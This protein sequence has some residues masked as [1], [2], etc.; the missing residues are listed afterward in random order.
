M[1]KI[2]PLTLLKIE[3]DGWVC[4]ETRKGTCGL[5]QAGM[6]AND[7]SK[8]RLQLAGYYQTSTTPG[9]W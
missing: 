3:H 8:E 7:L 5:P 2:L 1:T 6:L 4:V 9:L